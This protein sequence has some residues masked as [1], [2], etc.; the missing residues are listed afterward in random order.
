MESKMRQPRPWW[1][2]CLRVFSLILLSILLLVTTVALYFI[3]TEY[4]P[5]DVEDIAVT[6]QAPQLDTD[7][8]LSLLSWN[9]GFGALGD[10][11]DFFMDGGKMVH[12]SDEVRVQE[13]MQKMLHT[14]QNE[15]ADI[16][17]FQ[18]IDRDA[19]RSYGINQTEKF[20]KELAPNGVSTFANNFKVKY[21][22]Y[23][24]PPI[25]RVDSG[26][27]TLS[28]YAVDSAQ[29]IQ[30]PIPFKW[31][32]RIFNLKRALLVN[33]MPLADSDKE[34]VTIN[35]HMEAYD[36]GEGKAAQSKQLIKLVNE[37]VAKGNYVIAG[38]DFN[39]R[40][41]GSQHMHKTFSGQWQPGDL[42]ESVL[43]SGLQVVTGMNAPTC[44]SLKAPIVGVDP[45]D[46][47]YYQIDG[48]IVSNNL[49]VSKVEVLDLGFVNSDHNPVRLEVKFQ[50]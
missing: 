34:L 26:L 29:R 45:Q 50:K 38:G 20:T 16:M 27:L 42:D 35:V 39:Q 7:D 18:E 22:P 28:Q 30:L 14:L 32:E 33:R 23:P 9:I 8:G 6:A 21:L 12:P 19:K 4:K 40:F 1:V 36:S 44:R 31:P 5:K 48:F 37:E 24:W 15:K 25:G 2:R 10:N 47:Q 46:V 43:N 41:P 17:F 3:L 13:N 11:A 49:Q